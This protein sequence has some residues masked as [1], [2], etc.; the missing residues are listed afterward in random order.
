[1]PLKTSVVRNERR[2][3]KMTICPYVVV[4]KE[5]D[6]SC[7]E[8]VVRTGDSNKSVVLNGVSEV[9]LGRSPRKPRQVEVAH[10]FS[11]V[12][13]RWNHDTSYSNKNSDIVLPANISLLLLSKLIHFSLLYFFN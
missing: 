9:H 4:N 7:R 8:T 5:F 10:Q 11:A 6:D 12:D 13:S 1:M 2:R 3:V